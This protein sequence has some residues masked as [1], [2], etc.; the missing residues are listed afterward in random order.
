MMTLGRSAEHYEAQANGRRFPVFLARH[1]A[2]LHSIPTF[3]IRECT[4]FPSLGPHQNNGHT[5]RI[6]MRTWGCSMFHPLDSE[7]WYWQ[8][9][10]H[11]DR[12]DSGDEP[13]TEM[14]PS[15]SRGWTLPQNHLDLVIRSR[16]LFFLNEKKNGG[17]WCC[18]NLNVQKKISKKRSAL[19]GFSR[20]KN[21]SSLG[22]WDSFQPNTVTIYRHHHQ[23]NTLQYSHLGPQLDALFR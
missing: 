21:G 4:H 16:L 7:W 11:D 12:Q 5:N 18:H 14:R 13:A 15:R 10:R 9:V 1:A 20:L 17:T 22:R 6:H 23:D 2:L 19:S 8:D 3:G